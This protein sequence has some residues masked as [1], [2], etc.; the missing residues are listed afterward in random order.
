MRREIER[1]V[2]LEGQKMSRLTA[3]IIAIV[4][5]HSGLPWV[6]GNALPQCCF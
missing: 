6:A 3:I 1:E 5:C 2:C 4:I